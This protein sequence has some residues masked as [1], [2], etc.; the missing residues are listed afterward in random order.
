MRT[1][2]GKITRADA[3][4]F[5]ALR[6]QGCICCRLNDALGLDLPG[7]V[8]E[9]HHLL[10]GGRRRGHRY[11]IVCCRWHHRGLC[12][13]GRAWGNQHLGPSLAY[14]SK[15][16]HAHFGDDDHLLRLSDERIG[17]ERIAA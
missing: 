15:P 16:F 3:A 1:S 14:G 13:Y 11:T 6:E 5:E 17:A 7:N 9:V 12:I 2:T 4:R 8:L 10:S